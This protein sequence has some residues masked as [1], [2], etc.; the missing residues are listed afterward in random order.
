MALVVSPCAGS[1]RG[2]IKTA[3]RAAK[4]SLGM[5]KYS[6]PAPEPLSYS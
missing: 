4:A 1:V 5:P 2:I 3:A 6:V